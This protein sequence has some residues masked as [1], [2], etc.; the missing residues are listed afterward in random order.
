MNVDFPAPGAP[1]MPTRT[2]PPLRG[3]TSASNASASAR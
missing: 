3:R 1:E 2:A